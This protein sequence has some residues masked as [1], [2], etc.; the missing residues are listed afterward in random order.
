MATMLTLTSDSPL[1]RR[2]VVAFLDFLAI[3][4]KLAPGID[5]EGLEVA[6]Q[7]LS[8]VF[9]ISN[10]QKKYE[11]QS[12]LLVD[13][14]TSA[15]ADQGASIINFAGEN[16]TSSDANIVA[17]RHAEYQSSPPTNNIDV[18]QDQTMKGLQ[19][20]DESAI[21]AQRN[22][23]L[24][25]ESTKD[26]LFEQFQ[27]GLESTGYFASPKDS[28]DYN[29]RLFLAKQ[30]FDK[31][32]E[33]HMKGS[34]LSAQEQAE[35]LS[36]AYKLQGNWAMSTNLYREAI[37]LYT[38]AI[39]LCNNNAIL[40]ANRAA[41]HT[42]TG[43]PEAAIGDCK[44]AISLNPHYGKA[45]SRLGLAY[46]AQG[47]YHDAI[48]KG[49]KKAM[50]L[51]PSSSAVREN[52]QA[53]QQKLEEQQ[54]EGRQQRFGQHFFEFGQTSGLS[55]D[56]GPF[57]VRGQIPQELADVLPQFVNIATQFGETAQDMQNENSAREEPLAEE[58]TINFT[59]NGQQ[60]PEFAGIMQSVLGILE[61]RQGHQEAGPGNAQDE[62]RTVQGDLHGSETSAPGRDYGRRS[63]GVPLQHDENLQSV[64]QILGDL[65]NPQELETWA[66]QS[67][68]TS[69]G[70]TNVPVVES[71]TNQ[72]TTNH[73]A[74]Q[75]AP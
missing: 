10:W 32:F 3:G 15:S 59:I 4:L 26:L 75:D 36:E 18:H 22:P 53:A 17:E 64:S 11:A 52:L 8:E 23:T 14:F 19:P 72:A 27:E 29:S 48:E 34:I 42:Q 40:F 74:E 63:V 67:S 12:N 66:N 38:L 60:V 55:A 16:F 69:T 41:A 71:S 57:S 37:D 24:Q 30:T 5:G 70:N 58:S 49:Y 54:R 47:K 61:G 68:E 2:I 25:T 33:K 21:S 35:A 73:Q 20:M 6:I 62:S 39:S 44:T 50:E 65:Q 43:N 13:L 45:Y 46:Y 7:C 31:T 1:A 51:D 9:G 28:D 56:G